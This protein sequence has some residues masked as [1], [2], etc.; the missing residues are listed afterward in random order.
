M[1]MQIRD[2][3]WRHR[4][5]DVPTTPMT[6][7]E[8]EAERFRVLDEAVLRGFSEAAEHFKASKRRTR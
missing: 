7:E 3:R 5:I 6:D 4:V 8:F 1:K 2:Y